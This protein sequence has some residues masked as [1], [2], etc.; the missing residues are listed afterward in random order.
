MNMENRMN[1]IEKLQ[2]KENFTSAES[3]LADYILN[4]IDNVYRMSLQDLAKASYVSK[5]SVIRLYRKVGCTNYREFSIGLQLEKIKTDNPDTIENSKVFMESEDLYDYIQKVG[6]LCKQIVDNCIQSIDKDSIE[7]IVSALYEAKNIYLY[8]I[9][10]IR[11][12]LGFFMS[13]MAQIDKEPILIKENEEPEALI[14]SI[15]EKDAVLIVSI[16][17]AVEEDELLDLICER[18]FT[19]ILVTTADNEEL[20]LKTDYSFY[21]YPKGNDFIRNSTIVS[22]MSLLLG[23]NIIQACLIKERFNKK[24]D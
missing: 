23:L 4:N 6:V 11:Y 9:G 20:D 3:S 18:P 2:K 13:R 7:D 12:E 1:L 14:A 21:T 24:N 5:P 16:K 10:D 15:G 19:H 17:V 22:Q 8:T